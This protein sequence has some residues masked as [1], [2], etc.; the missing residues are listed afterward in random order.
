MI[1]VGYEKFEDGK[2]IE[3]QTIKLDSLNM[4]EDLIF[5]QMRGDYYREAR[6]SFPLKDDPLAMQPDPDSI[7]F[8]PMPRIDTVYKI[9]QI[10]ENGKI[11]FS[12]G[13]MTAGQKYWTRKMQ[14]WCLACHNRAK[15]PKFNFA[16]T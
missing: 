16:D 5:E 10:K 12:D 8:Q 11:I 4:L 2:W 15:A 13:F 1:T 3:E 7:K 14:D 6:I 9:H